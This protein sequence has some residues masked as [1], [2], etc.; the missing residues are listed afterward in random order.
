MN[1]LYIIDDIKILRI[2]YLATQLHVCHT[3]IC[4]EIEIFL[5]N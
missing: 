1:D 3:K 2:L 4:I 5:K